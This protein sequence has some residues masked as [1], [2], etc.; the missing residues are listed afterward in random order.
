MNQS[1]NEFPKICI[2]GDGMMSQATEKEA[3]RR[4]VT[5][6]TVISGNDLRNGWPRRKGD[7]KNAEVAIDFSAADAVP[8]TVK[9]CVEFG[10]P[11]VVGTTGWQGVTAEVEGTVINGEGALLHSPNFSITGSLLFHLLKLAG[12]WLDREGGFDPYI[13]ENHHASKKDA[14]SGTALRI[15]EILLDQMSEKDLLQLGTA[16]G[17]RASNLL[18]VASARAGSSPGRHIVGFDGEY[19]TLEL[20]HN[21]RDRGAYAAG[22]LRAAGWIRGRTGVYTMMDIVTDMI[23]VV[24][25]DRSGDD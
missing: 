17:E 20:V 21:V 3:R 19:E 25:A 22:A 14:P 12:A 10:I 6:T 9:R 1:G 24:T 8:G 2:F 5:L 18:S 13:F 15:G 16:S 7:L 4:G 11:I 23:D